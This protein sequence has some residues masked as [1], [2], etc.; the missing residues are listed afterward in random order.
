MTEDR[1]FCAAFVAVSTIG[2]VLWQAAAANDVGAM[3]QRIFMAGL[4]ML[5]M[6]RVLERRFYT[7]AQQER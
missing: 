2:G 6:A 3:W 7:R 4:F 1:L 5:V